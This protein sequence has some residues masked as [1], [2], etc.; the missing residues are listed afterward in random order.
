MN[1]EI[2]KIQIT[3]T[4]RNYQNAIARHANQ[5]VINRLWAKHYAAINQALEY[6][7]ATR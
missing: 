5:T 7:N 6:A 3:A 4:L 2:C 1:E